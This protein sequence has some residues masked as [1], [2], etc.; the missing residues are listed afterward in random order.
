M[1]L[2]LVAKRLHAD[3]L[4]GQRRH[5]YGHQGGLSPASTKPTSGHDG[6]SYV[7]VLHLADVA[8]RWAA[9]RRRA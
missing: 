2:G 3:E 9:A 1:R 8:A 5:P 6:H 4:P 7:A